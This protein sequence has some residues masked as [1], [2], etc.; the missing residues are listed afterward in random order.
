MGPTSLSELV[1]LG[2]FL[3]LRSAYKI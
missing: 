1:G 3:L 2:I